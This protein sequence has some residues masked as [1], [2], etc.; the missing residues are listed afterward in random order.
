MIPSRTSQIQENIP[1]HVAT[2]PGY[3][4]AQVKEDKN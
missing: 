1:K 4:L 3:L 2:H